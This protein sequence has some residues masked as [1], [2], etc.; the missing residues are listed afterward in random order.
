MSTFLV[1]IPCTGAVAADRFAAFLAE[2]EVDVAEV[3]GRHV[4]VPTDRPP[5]AF[6]LAEAAVREGFAHDSEAARAA[7]TFAERTAR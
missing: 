4:L 2:Q 5:F 3:A 6:D 7:T 1:S